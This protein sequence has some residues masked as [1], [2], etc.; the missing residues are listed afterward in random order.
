MSRVFLADL[1]VG[2]D[3]A[4]GADLDPFG[5]LGLGVDEGCVGDEG[6]HFRSRIPEESRP[7]SIHGSGLTSEWP[8]DRAVSSTVPL[9]IRTGKGSDPVG[10]NPS[11]SSSNG[12]NSLSRHEVSDL[13]P[14]AGTHLDRSI[15]MNRIFALGDHP[16]AH[17]GHGLDLDDPTLRA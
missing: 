15:S 10:L 11:I 7:E 4:V 8:L 13:R 6:G 1:D 16:A 3:H 14:L 2:A 12:D 9:P 17:P 5:D